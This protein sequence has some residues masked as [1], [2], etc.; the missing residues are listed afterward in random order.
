MELIESYNAFVER[1]IVVLGVG[2]GISISFLFIVGTLWY[3]LERIDGKEEECDES[4][5]N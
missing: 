5:A 3:F 2:L 1:A 4:T